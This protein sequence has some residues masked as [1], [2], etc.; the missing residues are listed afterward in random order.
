MSLIL[1]NVALSMVLR[2]QAMPL[3]NKLATLIAI[4]NNQTPYFTN[5][6][7]FGFTM[8]TTESAMMFPTVIGL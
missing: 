2:F 6:E 7:A 3:S 4:T 1:F 5:V 8:S